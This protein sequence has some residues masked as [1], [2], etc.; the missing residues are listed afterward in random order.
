[1]AAGPL[2]RRAPSFSH[3]RQVRTALAGKKARV[4]VFSTLYRSFQQKAAERTRLRLD[5]DRLFAVFA[6][7]I[8]EERGR[9]GL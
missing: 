3:S 6:C 2:L 4:S 1:M 8:T 5:H 7:L 9:D